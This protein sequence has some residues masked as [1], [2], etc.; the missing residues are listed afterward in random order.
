MDV[1][2]KYIKIARMFQRVVK[3][4]VSNDWSLQTTSPFVIK[5]GIERLDKLFPGNGAS[6]GRIVDFVV[7]QIYRFRDMIGIKGTRWN[8]LWCFS[9]KAVEKYKAQFL[10][11]DGKAG[12][13]YYIDQW[14]DDG[15]LNRGSLEKMIADTSKHRLSKLIYLPSEDSIK[16]RF[17]NTEF[18]YMLCLQATTGWTPKSP[19]CSVCKCVEKCVMSTMK[20]Y[21]ELV[22]LR[23]EN[24][25]GKK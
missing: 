14:L 11:K 9:D 16:K 13:M 21:P 12:M 1:D 10:D 18:G 24:S 4:L 23:K 5:C 15:E 20:K 17:V 6:D 2:Q 7:Y 19:I 8:V 25:N 3:R 22:R